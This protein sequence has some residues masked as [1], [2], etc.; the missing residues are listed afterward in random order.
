MKHCIGFRKEDAMN[1][2]NF[3]LLKL[4]GVHEPD[5]FDAIPT[6]SMENKGKFKVDLIKMKEKVRESVLVE[7]EGKTYLLS[8]EKLKGNKIEISISRGD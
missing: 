1:L 7:L 6:A 4:H 3:G 8:A 2:E 5:M